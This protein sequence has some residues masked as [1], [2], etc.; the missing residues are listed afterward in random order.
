MQAAQSSGFIPS[1]PTAS[2][3]I[4]T[5][6]ARRLS[7]A[8]GAQAG[9]GRAWWRPSSALANTDQE[10]RVVAL[11]ATIK[12]RVESIARQAR[13]AGVRH[14]MNLG[15]GVLPT[16]PEEN[17]AAFFEAGKSLRFD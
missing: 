16:T 5:M 6:K 17:V 13:D 7:P 10:L 11:Q 8:H 9:S 3:R 15:H 12:A 14:I 4:V 2:M 1:G